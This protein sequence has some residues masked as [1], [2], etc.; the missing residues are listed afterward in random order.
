M[1]KQV[2]VISTSPSKEAEAIGV[3]GADR[4]LV[5]R[6]A[7][8]MEAAADSLDGACVCEEV[9]GDG[10]ERGFQQN[11]RRFVCIDIAVC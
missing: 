6:D 10:E 7:A 11:L 2:T 8:A 5:S 9:W 3:L 4:F 1:N